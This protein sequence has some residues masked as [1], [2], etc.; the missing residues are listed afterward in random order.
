MKIT[1]EELTQIIKEEVEKNIS[2]ID[3]NKM[4]NNLRGKIK[5]GDI[6]KALMKLSRPGR[7]SDTDDTMSFRNM[8]LQQAK[9]A[10]EDPKGYRSK[11][12]EKNV[13]VKRDSNEVPLTAPFPPGIKS[14]RELI[15]KF[16]YKSKERD[17]YRKWYTTYGPG[18]KRKKAATKKTKS[19]LDKI[20]DKPSA[21]K[22]VS[23]GLPDRKKA[24]KVKD[25]DLK[26]GT[27]KGLS[28]KKDAMAA[29]GYDA[30]GTPLK[31]KK[32]TKMPD[33]KVPAYDP[34]KDPDAGN[35]E[36]ELAGVKPRGVGSGKG[37]KL[38]WSDLN[39][40]KDIKLKS[41][42]GRRRDMR[43]TF[44]VTIEEIAKIVEEE[45]EK[46]IGDKDKQEN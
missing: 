27:G 5:D 28:T 35:Y 14:A 8:A 40:F 39:P 10:D 30:D 12:K 42:S 34:S 36:K 26:P 44:N 22:K 45:I 6:A 32:G 37:G 13:D 46:A 33:L 21:S 20:L 24:K 18:S 1:K 7:R 29:L 31:R 25:L 16:P 3:L 9:D 4:L 43:E 2:E 38:K 19:D 41:R 17:D 11:A 23:G 15:K